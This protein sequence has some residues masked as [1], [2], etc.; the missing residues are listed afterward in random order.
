MSQNSDSDSEPSHS[1]DDSIPSSSSSLEKPALNTASLA[2]FQQFSDHTQLESRFQDK[3]TEFISVFESYTKYLA[4]E[5]TKQQVYL[6]CSC[7]IFFPLTDFL[8]YFIANTNK[9]KF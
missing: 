6:L 3:I 7:F 2:R 5:L 4:P 9:E 8:P 1:P